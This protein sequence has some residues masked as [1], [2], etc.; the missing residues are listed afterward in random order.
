M[1]INPAE[2]EGVVPIIPTLFRKDQSLD[3]EAVAACVRFAAKAG[4]KAVCLPAYGS[5]FYKLN[6]TERAQLI[7]TAV[8]A[9]GGKVL[10]IAQSNHPASVHAAQ[11]ARDNEARG[12]ELISFALPR[13]FALPEPD[14]LRYSQAVCSAV[15]L[16]ILIQDFNPNGSTIGSEFCRQLADSC[17]NF[18]Y[19]KLEEPLMAPKVLAIRQATAER[20]GILEGW[21]GMYLLE[22]IEPGICGLMPGL[23]MADLLGNVW[24]SAKAG[25]VSEAMDLFE[26]LLPQI[27]FS[28]QS[29][30]LFL[31]MEKDL[32]VR[33][34]VIPAESAHVRSATLSP[35]TDSWRHALLLNARVA[36]LAEQLGT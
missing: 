4:C 22:L 34:G 25:S 7:D 32:L 8:Q 30:E 12:A 5:E 36:R 18:R 28:L 23:A 13:L 3:Y 11:I 14:L 6:E 27:V 16:P 19:A 21:G 33:R 29:M 31:W 9:A 35:D 2:V 17:P 24:Q 1:A 20:V 26:K 10:V 15:K